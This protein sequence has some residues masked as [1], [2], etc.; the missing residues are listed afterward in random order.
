MKYNLRFTKSAKDDFEL[1]KNSSDQKKHFKAISKALAY[2]SKNP[3]H[4]SLNTHKYLN[5]FGDNGEEIFEAY[6]ENHS[7]EA[8][9]IFWHYGPE[10]RTIRVIAITAHP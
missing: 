4:P 8:Y 10:P 5:L 2:L 7:P 3:R 6:A 1:L 9:R